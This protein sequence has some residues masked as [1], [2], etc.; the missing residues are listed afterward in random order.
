MAT[1]CT[2]IYMGQTG[3]LRQGK[4]GMTRF[5]QH[6]QCVRLWHTLYGR[7][8]VRGLGK[9][10]PTMHR[11]VLEYFSVVP[12]ERCTKKEAKGTEKY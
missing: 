7:R 10:Y 3:A 2:R 11:I 6:L 8:A 9:L 4:R 12:L 1:K 5:M